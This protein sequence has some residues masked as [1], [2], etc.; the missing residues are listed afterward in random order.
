MICCSRSRTRASTVHVIYRLLLPL[1]FSTLPK[2][3]LLPL[4]PLDNSYQYYLYP[5]YARKSDYFLF[6]SARGSMEML[7]SPLCERLQV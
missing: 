6:R 1:R 4:Q 3:Y 2:Y 7:E 5:K